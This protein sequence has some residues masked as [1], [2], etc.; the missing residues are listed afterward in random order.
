MRQPQISISPWQQVDLSWARM[1]FKPSKSRSLVLQKG[2]LVD[3]FCFTISETTNPTLT[4][5]P[6][7]NLGKLFDFRLWKWRILWT[8]IHKTCGDLEA[9]LIRVYKSGLLGHSKA[10]IYKHAILP[11][12]LWPLLLYDV[13]MSTVEADVKEDQQLFVNVACPV[14]ELMLL[15]MGPP[16]FYSSPSVASQKNPWWHA[17]EK[18]CSIERA[19][20]LINFS[21]KRMICWSLSLSLAAAA[22]W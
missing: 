3:K 11:R 5:Q 8:A 12:L 10:W 17:R 21:A 13:L 20:Q 16:T 15:C 6:V 2:K 7:K 4:E 22:S 19:N 1:S 18:S 14:R 9:W